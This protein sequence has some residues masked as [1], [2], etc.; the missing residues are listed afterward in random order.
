[1][2]EMKITF[3]PGGI[4]QIDN[5]TLI[6]KN[7]DGRA[8]K[9]NREGDRNFAIRITDREI[10][11]ALISEGWNV[12][13]KEPLNEDDESHMRL[14]VKVKFNNWGP[15]VILKSGNKVLELDES[16]VG[17]LD[18]IRITN[19]VLDIKASNWEMPDG[20]TGRSAYLRTLF[21]EQ[22][23]D[24]FARLIEECEE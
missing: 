7:F 1:M 4:L 14:P 17:M 8:S 10:A 23:V 21:V 19:A 5:A 2:N 24:R 11:D 12:K 15:R 9:F 18:R 6:F 20:R 16:N 3:A 22:E 13:I